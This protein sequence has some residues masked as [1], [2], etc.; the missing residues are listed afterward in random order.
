MVLQKI[1][2]TILGE[3]E[4]VIRVGRSFSGRPWYFA[5]LRRKSIERITKEF[6]SVQ[7]IHPP[8][9]TRLDGPKKKSPAI[10]NANAAHTVPPAAI[11]AGPLPTVAVLDCGIPKNHLLLGSYVRGRYSGRN[12]AAVQHDHASLVAS[13]V[14]YGEI[15]FYGGIGA[16]PP[17]VV[18]IVDVAVADPIRSD[19]SQVVIEDED[20]VEAMGAVINGNPEVRVFNLSFS[21]PPLNQLGAVEQRQRLIYAQDLDNFIFANDVVVVMSA[22]NSPGGVQ[23]NQVFPEHIDDP[24]WALGGWVSGINTLKCGAYVG[25]PVATGIVNTVGWPSPFTRIGPPVS[26]AVAPE[27]SATGGDVGPNYQRVPG[28]GV[29]CCDST[30][31][32]VDNPGTSFA[33]PLIAR[34]AALTYDRLQRIAGRPFGALVRAVMALTAKSS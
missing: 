9:R 27:F 32:W 20:V 1:A 21:G 13:R 26:Q 10:T 17:G 12:S 19:S 11:A 22:G 29:W 34:E 3:D 30:G 31:M 24:R 4:S 6:P 33:A 8:L 16:P 5:M 2:T 23:P 7:A 15:N 18:A 28:G 25:H 14:V